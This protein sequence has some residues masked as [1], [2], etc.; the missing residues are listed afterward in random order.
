[1]FGPLP[2]NQ[3]PYADLLNFDGPKRVI[4]VRMDHLDTLLKKVQAL[5]TEPDMLQEYDWLDRS[6]PDGLIY[7]IDQHR[8]HCESGKSKAAPR[9]AVRT[10]PPG[11]AARPSRNS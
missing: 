1:M 7:D 4:V 9:S 2:T 10:E 3:S 8:A 6:R 11:S 5:L